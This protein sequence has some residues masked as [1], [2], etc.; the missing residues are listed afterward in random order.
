M[1]MR[2]ELLCTERGVWFVKPLVFDI[3]KQCKLLRSE[4]D[5]SSEIIFKHIR[6]ILFDGDRRTTIVATTQSKNFA[7]CV[8]LRDA[9][10]FI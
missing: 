1:K 4:D 9:N 3:F 2:S 7:A 6:A 8:I 5:S 10:R